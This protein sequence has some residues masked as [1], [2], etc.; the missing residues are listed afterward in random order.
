[1]ICGNNNMLDHICTDECGQKE[2]DVMYEDPISG[3]TINCVSLE[4]YMDDVHWKICIPCEA[5]HNICKC[6]KYKNM[7]SHCG[8]F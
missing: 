1:M 5:Y 7:Y 3:A 4:G 2:D 8:F 6:K